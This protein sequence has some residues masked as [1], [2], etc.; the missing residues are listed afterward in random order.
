MGKFEFKIALSKHGTYKHR[1]NLVK[2]FLKHSNFFKLYGFGWDKVP[3]PFDIIGIAIINRVTFMK[4]FVK[5]LEK[6]LK[7]PVVNVTPM[8]EFLAKITQIRG[9]YEVKNETKI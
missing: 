1:Y 7:A 9:N 5:K 6:E 2:N 3:L 8:A 4:K